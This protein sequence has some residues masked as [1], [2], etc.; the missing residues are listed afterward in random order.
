MLWVLVKCFMMRC[1]RTVL[2]TFRKH[3]DLLN[4]A[5]R[6]TDH[7][8][9]CNS[10]TPASLKILPCCMEKDFMYFV[11]FAARQIKKELVSSW[12]WRQWK[13]CKQSFHKP[14]L[15][16]RTNQQNLQAEGL[17][18]SAKFLYFSMDR[19]IYISLNIYFSQ[20]FSLTFF[21]SMY[22]ERFFV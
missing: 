5:L 3:A 12:I 6:S 8:G 2:G 15:W 21:G 16:R 14:Y 4:S 18:G 19:Y 11:V 20:Y 13:S 7:L 9:H 22:R 1:S 17:G 10:I